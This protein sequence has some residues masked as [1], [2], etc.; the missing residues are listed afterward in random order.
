VTITRR[1]IP[2]D[3]ARNGLLA[4]RLYLSR[5]QRE[6]H[7]VLV[8]RYRLTRGDLEPLLGRDLDGTRRIAASLGGSGML[9]ACSRES[10]EAF[11]GTACL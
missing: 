1:A 4:G 10:V 11:Q 3:A 6:M 9:G 5:N 2:G 8:S 7:A